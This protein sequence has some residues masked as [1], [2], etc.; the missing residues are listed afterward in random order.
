MQVEAAL[1]DLKSSLTAV[2]AGLHAEGNK[3]EHETQRL[4]TVADQALS[5]T[6]DAIVSCNLAISSLHTPQ[7]PS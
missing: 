1:E 2:T 7:E 6:K 3:L 4:Y 5:L